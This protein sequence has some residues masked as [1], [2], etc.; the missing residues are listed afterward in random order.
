MTNQPN[1]RDALTKGL[2]SLLLNIDED[3]R[4]TSSS[5]GGKEIP[6]VLA[7]ERIPLDQIEV[8]PKQPRRDFD[9]SSLQEL[10]LS[11]R[12]HDLIQPITVSRIQPRKYRLISGERRLRASR[13]AGLRDIP[14]FIRQADDRQLLELALTENLHRE[15]LNP[16][17]LAMGYRRLMDECALSQ[18]Q[19][20]EQ[21]GKERSTVSNYIRLLKLP[22][23]IQLAVRSGSLS[24]GHARALLSI[25][26]VEWQLSV[27][28]EVQRKQL[29][30]RQTEELVRLAL[31]PRKK[32]SSGHEPGGLPTAYRQIEDQLSSYFSTRV[33]LN[34][35]RK[36]RGNLSI[37]FYSDD[38]L[39]RILTA[40]G[41][42]RA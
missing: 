21:M 16:M 36:G 37:D 7:M 24:M 30:V 27:F 39:D 10:S 29:S 8:N 40:L 26:K 14:A 31:Q 12:I 32:P 42:P 11:I 18:E 9:E 22:P 28:G 25:D 13:M 23:D 19:V 4:D 6:T 17:E 33:R 3:L 1:K 38:E 20:A 2:R 35:G 5:L 41:L 15:D 34:R